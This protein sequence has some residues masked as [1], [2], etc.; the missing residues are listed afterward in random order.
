MHILKHTHITHYALPS[1]V[2]TTYTVSGATGAY[3]FALPA[4]GHEHLA[5][6][7]ASIGKTPLEVER[8][9]SSDT[10][11][12]VLYSAA[13]GD[14]G[15]STKIAVGTVLLFPFL[16]VLFC[17]CYCCYYIGLIQ[18]S[19]TQPSSVSSVTPPPQ[20]ATTRTRHRAKYPPGPHWLRS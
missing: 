11:G 1:Q 15:V 12:L 5:F 19:P 3:K 8:L 2:V 17:R 6:L 20:H 18:R 7:S 13:V 10:E 16:C 14:P 4:K 9:S